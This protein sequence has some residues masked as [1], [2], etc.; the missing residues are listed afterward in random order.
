MTKIRDYGSIYRRGN[1]DV[2]GLVKINLGVKSPKV[3]LS[4]YTR[5]TELSIEYDRGEELTQFTV[6]F[7][8]IIEFNLEVNNYLDLSFEYIRSEELTQFTVDFIYILDFNL[9]VLIKIY[10][11]LRTDPVLLQRPRF[12]PRGLNRDIQLWPLGWPS[13]SSSSS[14]T[15]SRSST[16]S[17]PGSNHLR[18]QG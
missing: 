2:F 18:I 11:G 4:I 3:A 17:L 7:I 15:L 8:Y 1:F 13:S 12:Q 6:D 16:S 10:R 14:L 5:A 9:E